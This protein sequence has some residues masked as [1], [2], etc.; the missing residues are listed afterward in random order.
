ML[1]NTNQKNAAT[2][3][4]QI[5]ETKVT[6]PQTETIIITVENNSFEIDPS[7]FLFAMAEGNY[8]S[9]YFYKDDTIT[10]QLKRVSLKNIEDQLAGSSTAVIR[11]HRSFLVNPRHIEK[12]TGNAQGY[13]LYFPKIDFAVPVSRAQLGNFKAVIQPK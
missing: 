3:E 13:Q 1:F 6:K 11:T 8:T 2:T 4:Q 10:K 7:I 12:I 5:E 9:F